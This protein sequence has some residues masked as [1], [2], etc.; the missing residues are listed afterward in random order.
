MV[1]PGNRYTQYLQSAS[2]CCC[3]MQW[4]GWCIPR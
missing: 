1:L 2:T 4:Q 3:T